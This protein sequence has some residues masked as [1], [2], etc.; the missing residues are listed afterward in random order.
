ME[1]A[2][3]FIRRFLKFALMILAFIIAI[4]F[5][6]FYRGM[7]W[8]GASIFIIGA[9]MGALAMDLLRTLRN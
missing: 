2:E 7:G 1:P 5:G 6:E 3:K 4:V 9:L 8:V